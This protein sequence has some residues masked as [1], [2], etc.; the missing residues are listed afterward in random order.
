MGCSLFRSE[1]LDLL[2]MLHP[3]ILAEKPL[4]NT[5]A[6]DEQHLVTWFHKDLTLEEDLKKAIDQTLDTNEKNCGKHLQSGLAGT[7]SLDT[8]GTYLSEVDGRDVCIGCGF[9]ENRPNYDKPSG[10]GDVNL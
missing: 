4:D 7:S 10:K 2:V 3:N 1:W 6:E 8:R 9:S 5:K